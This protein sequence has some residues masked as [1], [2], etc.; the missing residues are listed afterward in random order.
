MEDKD[1]IKAEIVKVSLGITPA[2]EQEF[3][4]FISQYPVSGL[5]AGT[6]AGKS[7]RIP[8][9]VAKAG[10]RV[11]V[12]QPTVLAA[13]FAYDYVRKDFDAGYVGYA[14]EG[15]VNYNDNTQIIYCTT[16]HLR[17]KML[18]YFQKGDV[19]SGDISFCDV[20]LLDEAHSG[21]LDNDVI[22][23]LWSYAINKDVAVPKM[24]LMSA[25]LS[26]ETTIFKNLPIYEIETPSKKII[27][28]YHDK[29]YRDPTD[30]KLY[31]DAASVV[32]TTSTLR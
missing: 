29:D 20:I 23:E 18:S 6:G 8:K 14:V 9:A 13:F 16:G 2:I 22:M 32:I 7:S 4:E 1:N 5:I 31:I 25:T 10:A 19:P 30:K 27:E 28:Y 15:N 24:V 11:F 12:P 3:I 21:S 17:N 26:K